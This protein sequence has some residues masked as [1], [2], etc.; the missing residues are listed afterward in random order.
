MSSFSS[1]GKGWI[2]VLVLLL[3]FGVPLYD[4][5]SDVNRN[6]WANAHQGIAWFE[7]NPLA[8]LLL[9]AVVLCAFFKRY[10]H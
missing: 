10:K 6:I 9:L 2:V 4:W 5:L 7:A 3:V 1:K 8:T